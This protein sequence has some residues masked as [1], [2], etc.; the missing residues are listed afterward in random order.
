MNKD[1]KKKSFSDWVAKWK[2]EFKAHYKSII[3]SVFLLILAAVIDYNAGVYV[4][5]KGSV[6]VSDFILDNIGPYNLSFIFIYGWLFLVGLMVIYP[7]VFKVNLFHKVLSQ[8]SILIIIRSFFM[9]LTHLKTPLDAIYGVF[10]GAI[11]LLAFQNDLFFSG[12]TAVPF[13]GFLVYR[14]HKI[15][16]LFLLGSIIM[17]ITVLLMHQHYTIDVFAAYFITYGTY[18]LAKFFSPFKK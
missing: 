2:S 13:L 1:V 15:R 16:W 3:F 4:T 10:P 9:T 7:I 14:G 6:V 8:F 17:G 12:H 18:K 11:S 5:G